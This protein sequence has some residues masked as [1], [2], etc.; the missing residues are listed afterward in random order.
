M[1]TISEHKLDQTV[2]IFDSFYNIDVTVNGNEFDLVR[3]FF[4]S[5]C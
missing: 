2:Q 3:C 1:P 4:V 5:I